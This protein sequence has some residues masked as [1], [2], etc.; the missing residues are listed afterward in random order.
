M[1]LESV[2]KNIVQQD[3]TCLLIGVWENTR[4]MNC[5]DS[6]NL[7]EMEL[8]WFSLLDSDDL[9]IVKNALRETLDWYLNEPFTITNRFVIE[10]II[11]QLKHLNK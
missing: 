7:F 6:K 3:E 1:Y 11:K 9:E 10:K 5:R 8:S 4:I 2:K